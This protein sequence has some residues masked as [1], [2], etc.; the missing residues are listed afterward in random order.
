MKENELTGHYNSHHV[1]PGLIETINTDKTLRMRIEGLSGSS[2][3]LVLSLVFQKTQTTHVVVIPEKEDAAY[4]YND[5]VSLL[6]EESVY[7]F[8]STYKRSVQ[9]EQTEPA[10]IVLR[11]EVLNHLTSGKRKGIIVT[12]PESAMEKVVSRKN[13]KKNTFNINK[14]DKISLEFL[15]E[16]LHEY[17]FVRTDFVYEPGQ[18][19]IRGS[20]ADVFSY[21]ADLPYRI[22]F[23]G[24]E[25]ET[26]RSFNTDDQLS[27]S[28][29]K[30]ISI[31]PNIQ[32]ISIEEIN[33]SFTDFLPPSS[34][35]WIEEAEY[36]KEKIN[37]IFF[38]TT[39]REESGQISDKKEIVMTG[40][41][42]LDHCKKFRI[43]EFGKQGMFEPEARY[44]FNTEP[45]PVFNKNFELLSDKLL[46]NDA[47]N[48]VTY[49]ISESESQIE[50][51]R[52]IF[53]E[54]NP[55]T[56]F[57][58]MMLNLHSGF[59]DHDLRI[60]VYTDHQIF[61]RYHKFRIRGYFTK[62]ES[63]SVKELTGLN[64]GDYVVH[65]DHGIGKFG[66]LE[67]IEVNGKIQEAIK[68][69]YRDNDILY[70]G[71]HSLHRISKYKGKDNSEPKI[72]KLGSGAWQKLKLSTKARVK[73]IAKDLIILYAKRMSSP[74]YSFSPDSYLQRELE[75]SFI[76]EDTPDQLTASVAVKGDMEAEHPMDRLVCGDVGFGKTEIAIRAAFK[77]ASDS[78]QTAVLVPTTILALQHYKT[79]SARLKGFPCNIE[80]ISRHKKAAE[81]KKILAQLAEGKIDILIG[82]HKLV[83]QDVK[84]KDL[85]LL[86]IDEE[87]RFGVSVKEKLKK[88][89][90]NVDTLTLTATPIPR[91]LQFSLMG[92]RDLS[93][94]NTPPPNRMPIVTEL[95]GYNEEI[96]KEG[97]EYE[98]SRNG[99]VFFIHNRVENIKQIQAV[100]NRICPNVKTAIVHG[101]MDGTHVENVMFDFIQ[102]DYD[103]LLATTIIE[104][105][106]DIPNANTIFINDAH[107]FG[108]SELHQLRGRVG[109]SNKKAFCY[110]LAPPLSTLT[111]EARRRLKAIEEFSELGS[112]FNI[113]MQDLDI[114]GSG[115]LLGGEQSGFIADVGFETYQRILNEAMVE[116]RESGFREQESE[117]ERI[118]AP[119]KALHDKPYVSDF[120]I[121]TDLA[122][123]FP[124]EY[125]S[126]IS[127]RIR[128]YKELNEIESDEALAL[129]EKKLIDRF[130]IIPPPAEALLDIV[131]I[132]WIAVKLGIEKILLKNNLLIANF[133]SD[134][135]SQFYRSA[136]FVSIMNYVNRKSHRMN[137]KQKAAKLSLTVSDVRT[138]KGAIHLLNEILASH[139]TSQN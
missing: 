40:S 75:A 32:D 48:Y 66:G 125:I 80:Y 49:I 114:R 135:N 42:F 91:T 104:S 96:I 136:L 30:Q 6:G 54:I 109:R 83:G 116:L 72:Y 56:H 94:I 59:T 22:D 9:Y 128:L 103:V 70:V 11:T 118:A 101:Q 26:I 139:Q 7:F 112:G 126:N 121:D 15:E 28:I 31:I 44:E 14:G 19:S 62:K 35:I 102:G 113:A 133:V 98:V 27:V 131:R 123:M 1:L 105:G 122:I 107:H 69:V 90:A 77:S 45:Q 52:D 41:H 106:L 39:Q 88:I 115:N 81:Q 73:D 110:L 34:L 55:E 99:Q 10:N 108:L 86:V 25:V 24:E 63:I 37:N 61:D 33:D 65:I 3:A 36:I 47:E 134:H 93:I 23:F 43:I 68:L 21:S 111:H 100:I 117:G 50:R 127:E 8:P 89:K 78:K 92:A 132:K 16:M 76:Y 84:F 5:L 51:L 13:L 97:I 120:Q 2:R 87:Q 29:H 58:P 130:G 119:V 4:F 18:Y 124:D 95:H 138:V 137:M 60:S 46:S 129:F 82:T 53:S 57:N 38:Q 12:Y 20:I 64:P 71:I 85:G 79:F 74:G 67:K 17:N